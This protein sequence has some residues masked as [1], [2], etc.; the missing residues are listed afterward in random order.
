MGRSIALLFLLLGIVFIT[1]GYSKQNL[2][3]PPPEIEYR[4][5]PKTFYEEQ[6]TNTQPNIINENNPFMNNLTY[7]KLADELNIPYNF[8]NIY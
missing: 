3:C 6:L 2:K 7:D 1:I 4:L 5:I 8:S